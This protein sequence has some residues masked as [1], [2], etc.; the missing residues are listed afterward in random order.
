MVGG[1]ASQREG[2]RTKS[3][4]VVAPRV[5]TSWTTSSVT[6]M[7]SSRD[8]ILGEYERAGRFTTSGLKLRSC[9]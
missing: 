8:G 5:L 4:M 9:P 3:L 1:G 2:Q 6:N 7:M